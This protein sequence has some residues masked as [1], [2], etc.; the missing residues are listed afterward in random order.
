MRRGKRYVKSIRII[1]DN[2]DG[3][4]PA[5]RH[6]LVFEFIVEWTH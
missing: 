6:G 4:V 3:F 1:Y 5:D 2:I